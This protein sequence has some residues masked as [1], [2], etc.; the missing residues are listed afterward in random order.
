MAEWLGKALQKPLQRFESARDL[1]QLNL[2][3]CIPY[4][5]FKLGLVMLSTIIKWVAFAAAIGLIIGCY[6]PWSY[7]PEI[8]QY[9]S[10]F[11]SYQNEYGRPGVLIV[12]LA[13]VA[14][15]FLLINK[16]W[17]KRANL[18][19]TALLVGYVIKSYVL[20]TNC[21]GI[22]CPIKQPIVNF[23]PVFAIILLAGVI[24]SK[25]PV[26]KNDQ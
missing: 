12:P 13:A 25:L 4:R 24:F 14:A 6:L 10:G 16:L 1:Q 20:F 9:F 3:G 5:F 23:L 19:I 15:L 26:K 8:K 7:F 17:A 2:Y 21:Y 11:Y 22:F 18:F